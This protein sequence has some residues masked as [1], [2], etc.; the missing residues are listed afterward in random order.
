MVAFRIATLWLACYTSTLVVPPS[1]RADDGEFQVVVDELELMTE[2]E[3][4][5]YSTATLRREDR[6]VVLSKRRGWAAIRPPADAFDWV[7]ASEVRDQPDGSCVISADR[8]TIRFAAE[9]ARM[10]GPPCSTL[11]RGAVVHLVDHP[12]LKVGRGEDARVWRAI[13][14]RPGEV[15]YVRVDGLAASNSHQAVV[16]RRTERQVSYRPEPS[17]ADLPAEVAAELASINAMTRSVKA[18]PVESW[19]LDP[20]RGRY[21]SL[22]R[23]F[24]DNPDVKAAVQ[25]RL[26]QTVRDIELAKTVRRLAQLLQDSEERDAKVEQLQRSLASARIQSDRNY[27][28]Q[29]LLQASSRRYQGQRVHALIGPEGRAI[30]YLTIPPGIPIN[31]FL[32]R[33]VGVRGIVRFDEGLGARLISVRDLEVIEKTR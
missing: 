26:D 4:S 1:S 22:L 19:N 7:D 25:P 15:R 27:D 18:G 13:D 20:V 32:A 31:Q 2:P 21:E 14:P 8:S 6:V 16:P 5:A 33:K 11:A 23:Q 28:A 24:A 30:G 3:D 17:E 9:S 10:P 29:G 12:E